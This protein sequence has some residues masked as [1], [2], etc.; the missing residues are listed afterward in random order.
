MIDVIKKSDKYTDE[1]KKALL[2]VAEDVL[3]AYTDKFK[4]AENEIDGICLVPE[5]ATNGEA[6][7]IL[8]E[9]SK[10]IDGIQGK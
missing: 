6:E 9:Y 10:T 4:E 3:P 2:D 5:L 1:Q 8:S 7:D